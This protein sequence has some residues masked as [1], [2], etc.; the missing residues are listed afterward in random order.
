MRKA[1]AWITLGCC[2][3]RLAALVPAQTTGKPGLWETTVDVTWQQL[4][5]PK[6]TKLAKS[7]PFR[8]THIT[9]QVCLT[10]A[11]L[12]SFKGAAPLTRTT[13]FTNLKVSP[14]GITA[15][16]SQTGNLS[17]TGIGE[18]SWTD[19][20]HSRSSIHYTGSLRAG[21]DL[22][23]VAWTEEFTSVFKNA[24]CGDIQPFPTTSGPVESD[25]KPGLWKEDTRYYSEDD[26]IK[27]G[28]ILFDSLSWSSCFR[29]GHSK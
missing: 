9:S 12:E 4:P 2:L 18:A 19:S 27:W 8:G 3:F 22:K 21:F 20:E 13:E 14:S 28:S 6:E 16:A 11:M 1:L 7:S 29:R 15:R 24:S 10:Q 26:P 23:P 25:R 5:F 17:G